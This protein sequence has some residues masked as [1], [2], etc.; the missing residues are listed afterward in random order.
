MNGKISVE[1]WT[2][3]YNR[4]IKEESDQHERHDIERIPRKGL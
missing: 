4:I 2:D 3:Y 1:E